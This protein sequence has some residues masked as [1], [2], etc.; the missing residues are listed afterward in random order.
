[1]T[2]LLSPAH[3]SH[4]I[5]RSTLV[6]F[7][8]GVDSTYLL[9]KLLKETTDD[10]LA[11]HVHLFNM[12]GRAEVEA[13]RCRAM[14]AWLRQ[15]V[16]PFSY[17][18]TALDHRGLR[19]FG[20]DVMA[21]AFEAGL[22]ANSYRMATGRHLD[23]FV[24]GFCTDEAEQRDMIGRGVAH[25]CCAANC[26]PHPAPEFWRAPAVSKVEELAYLPTEIRALAWT[27]RRPGRSGAAFVECGQCRTC[28]TM[29]QARLELPMLLTDQPYNT[30]PFEPVFDAPGLGSP[31]MR[32]W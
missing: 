7:S 32:L 10:V 5:P 31:D 21:S 13:E 8:G 4:P 26:F 17:S 14:A 18:E 28:T 29:T 12:E 30:P 24:H 11:H 25:A 20:S 22:V 6:M 16:R 15:N 3:A 1:M 9:V 19:W 2:A 23:R 27:C